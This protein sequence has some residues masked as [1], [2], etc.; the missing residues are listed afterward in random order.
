MVEVVGK[1]V[2]GSVGLEE[3]Y[4][5]IVEEWA[6]VFEVVVKDKGVFFHEGLNG[7]KWVFV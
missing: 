1:E 2:V 3:E 4:G 5:D 6:L 7:F